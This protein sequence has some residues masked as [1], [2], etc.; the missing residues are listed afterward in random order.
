MLL[1]I[2]LLYVGPGGV[3]PYENGLPPILLSRDRRGVVP[4][5]GL[6]ALPKLPSY[7]YNNPAAGFLRGNG[8]G[9]DRPLWLWQRRKNVRLALPTCLRSTGSALAKHARDSSHG[10]KLVRV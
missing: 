1:K 3:S 4:L 2:A 6:L 9:K 10:R 7:H 8:P 5:T